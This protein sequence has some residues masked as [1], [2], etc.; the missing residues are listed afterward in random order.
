[1]IISIGLTALITVPFYFPGYP[2]VLMSSILMYVVLTVGWVLFSGPTGYIFLA[3]AAFFGAG[4]YIAAIFGKVL[5]FPL[6][7]TVGGLASCA[8]AVVAGALG[9][10]GSNGAGK[11]TLFDLISAA[12]PTSL[13]V[14]TFKNRTITGLEPY[15]IFRLGL[16]RTFQTVKIFPDLSVLQNVKL[17]AYFGVA[18]S[19]NK[20]RKT[21]ERAMEVLAFVGLDGAHSKPA[22]DLT[23]SD[24]KPLEMARALVT[25][26]ELLLLDEIMAGLTQT[27]VVQA[28]NLITQIRKKGVTI[29]MIEH[30]M[31][32]IMSLGPRIMVLHHGAK[33][34]EGTPEE[35]S[36]GKTVIDIYSGGMAHAGS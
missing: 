21:R 20:P 14:I 26:P 29:I 12:L 7:V 3:P 5:P 34:D 28:M 8:M 24:Q 32:A 6:V 9:L 35:I 31:R 33:I 1:M 25:E 22:K 2:V 36:N 30:V 17:G 27:E 23:L 19:T 10:I 11:T 15:K 13:G 16:A 4:I 18:D